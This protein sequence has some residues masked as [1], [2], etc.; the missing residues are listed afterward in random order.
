M[1]EMEKV[2]DG[3]KVWL[4]TQLRET[5]TEETRAVGRGSLLS[6]IFLFSDIYNK[7]GKGTARCPVFA[8]LPEGGVWQAFRKEGQVSAAH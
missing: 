1:L 6:S 8:R 4:Q 2:Q 5:H 7:M 3:T